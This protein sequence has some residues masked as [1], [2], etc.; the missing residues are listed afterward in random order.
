MIA[1]D[2]GVHPLAPAFGRARFADVR[3]AEDTMATVQPAIR[4]PGERVQHLVRVNG[5]IPAI[6]KN[7]RIAAGL[8]IFPIADRHKHQVRRGADPNAAEADL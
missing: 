1:P 6:Q 7:L 5:V 4:S 3:R 2:A 8:R